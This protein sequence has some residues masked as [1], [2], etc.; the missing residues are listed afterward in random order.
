MP[1][2][3][4]NGANSEETSETPVMKSIRWREVQRFKFGSPVWT[5]FEL[6]QPLIE[7]LSV[8]KLLTANRL[9]VSA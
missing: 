2:S 1:G 9:A 3:L 6:W 8:R 5:N 7:I 4:P